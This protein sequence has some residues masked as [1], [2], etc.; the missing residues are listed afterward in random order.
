MKGKQEGNQITVVLHLRDQKTTEGILRCLR[1]CDIDARSYD[2]SEKSGD[3]GVHLHDNNADLSRSGRAAS[4]GPRLLL[5]SH[6]NSVLFEQA[7]TNGYRGFLDVADV[8][9]RICEAVSLLATGEAFLD[10]G[11]LD[12]LLARNGSVGLTNPS[13]DHAALD[14]LT[15]REREVFEA[16]VRGASIHE[17]GVSLSISERT[18][19]VHRRRILERLG[20]SNVV[21]LFHL[22][23]KAGVVTRE[24]L[25]EEFSSRS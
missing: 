12:L 18:V 9:D 1:A 7:V 11:A 24:E 4:P 8:S 17:I 14:T 2:A 21:Q 23:F 25:L 15:P 22:A 6:L 13:Y 16:L 19:E 10:P 5:Y 3:Y 20:L